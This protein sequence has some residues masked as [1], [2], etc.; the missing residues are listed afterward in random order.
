MAGNNEA[1]ETAWER[2]SAQDHSFLVAED[3]GSPMH[4]GAVQVFAAGVLQTEAGGV[5][6]AA[7]R[8]AIASR[9]PL[10]PRY[11]QKLLWTPVENLPVWVDDASFDIERHVRHVSLPRPGT[12]EQ[13]WEIA[14]SLFEESLDRRRPLWEIWVI[15]GLEGGRYAMVNRV[16]HAMMDG[17]AGSELATLLYSLTPEQEHGELIPFEPRPEP[18]AWEMLSDAVL[19]RGK[20]VR[21][22]IEGVVDAIL[23]PDLLGR[24]GTA[25]ATMIDLSAY[26]MN[27]VSETPLNGKV[28]VR[29][30][31]RG[32]ELELADVKAMSR[33]TG[34]TVND[35]VLAAVSGAVREHLHHHGI[36]PSEATFR[37]SAPVNVRRGEEKGAVAGNRV[38]SWIVPAPLQLASGLGRLDAVHTKTTQLKN[39]GEA[40]VVDMVM[41]LAEFAPNVLLPLGARAASGPMSM[42]VTNVPG[43]QFP[44]YMQGSK[45]E[46]IFCQGPVLQGTGVCLALF[47]YDGKIC[48]GFNADAGLVAD[49][50]VFVIAVKSA[51]LG[52]QREIQDRGMAE[53]V[54]AIAALPKA[55]SGFL[56]ARPPA[57][58]QATDN[59]ASRSA[60]LSI[61]G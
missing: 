12:M 57:R 51:F 49:L 53:A 59:L 17:S 60:P 45:L 15:E 23:A 37:F 47:S 11:R 30:V 24:A 40:G 41:R 10:I 52:L 29:R 42:V 34:T 13:L 16:H 48:L 44:L 20:L 28:G 22:A 33:A 56:P 18:S 43:P 27:P 2:L 61:A 38:A 26:S 4:I 5:D 35:V 3:Q 1:G 8:R 39:S 7:I 32:F 54:G 19:R 31:F 21:T 46:S 6:I 9:L 25:A 14:G 50:D 36:E 58:E 55:R